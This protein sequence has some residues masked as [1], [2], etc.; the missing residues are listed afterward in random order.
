MYEFGEVNP[1]FYISSEDENTINEIEKLLSNIKINSNTKEKNLKIKSKVRSIHSSLAIEANSLSLESVTDILNNKSVLG[2]KSEIQEVKNA[3]EL[4]DNIRNFNWR[5][6]NDF[7]KAHLILMKY[8]DDDNGGYR[9]H[10][11]GVV[12]DEK[13]IFTAPDSI[14]VPSLMKNL[15]KFIN[16][17]ENKIHP[18]VLSAIFHYYMVYIHPF[19]DGNGRMARFWVSLMLKDFNENFEFIPIEEEIYINQEE[20]YRSISECHN[21]N[22][23]NVFIKFILKII[24]SAV[25]KTTQKTTQ[26]KLTNNQKKIIE[27]IKLNQK[28][29]RSE[30]AQKTALSPDGVKYNLNKLKKDNIIERIGP[31][32][33]GYWKINNE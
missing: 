4:Y 24:K 14:L 12:K 8:F 1:I 31:K 29:T 11:E 19:T 16:E 10:G 28:I 25:Q 13:I 2:K 21:N 20:Y 32:N 23:A 27:L 15:F 26:I 33:G 5:K 6:E 18:L 17:N 30:I 7:I 22:N 9:N 3:I